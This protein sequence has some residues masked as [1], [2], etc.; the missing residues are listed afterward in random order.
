[1]EV[2]D[3]SR[4][5]SWNVVDI[6]VLI[7]IVTVRIYRLLNVEKIVRP[8]LLS[9]A[10]IVMIVVVISKITFTLKKWFLKEMNNG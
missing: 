8:D 2:R 5:T 9:V 6:A 10:V 3:E 7:L 4:E 1:M